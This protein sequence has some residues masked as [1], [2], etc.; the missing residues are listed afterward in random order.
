[1]SQPDV[2]RLMRGV[3]VPGAIAGLVGGF[4]F[5]LVV[6]QSGTL[7][8]VGP[9][10]RT[11]PEAAGTLVALATGTIAGIGL[12]A[13]LRGRRPSGDMV[14]WA[15][16]YASVVWLLGAVT[17]QPWLSGQ[18]PMWDVPAAQTAYPSLMGHILWGVVAGLTLVAIRSRFRPGRPGDL[19]TDDADEVIGA[20]RRRG[21]IIRGLLAGSVGYLVIGLLPTGMDRMLSPW[22]PGG[23]DGAGAF[24]VALVASVVYALLHPVSTPSAGAAIVR[25]AGFGSLLWVIGGLTVL[26]LMRGQPLEWSIEDARA[27][28]AILPGLILFGA[29]VALLYHWSCR[30]ARV[31]VA[32][33]DARRP[34]DGGSWGP[35]A[36]VR[37]AVA[38]LVGGLVFTLVMLQI[39]YLPSVARLV[40]SES[41]IVGLIVH[42][43]IAEVVGVSYAVL[44]RRQAFDAASAIGWGVSYGLLWWVLGPLTL[45][46]VI[47]GGS[48]AWT[49]EAAA[50]AFPSL[51]GHMAYGAA[52]GLSCHILETR[53]SP[54]WITRTDAEADRMAQSRRE[55]TSAGPALWA[56]LVIMAV[57]LPIVL[58]R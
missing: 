31:F 18:M 29:V 20:P 17:L 54:W 11:D 22:G 35:R 38:G 21:V 58:T 24:G 39:G 44:F 43:L 3:V 23:D 9:V 55:A 8:T 52:L 42:L 2:Q 37:G 10:V 32:D 40:G 26:P 12:A 7:L 46:P 45:A 47:L 1:M 14:L 56:I 27:V 33:A 48:P 25:G 15:V 34:P 30:I 5:D 57:L 41:A 6:R 36:I 13:L 53:Y 51:I 28:F 19:G 49:V 4:A 50:V 16:A